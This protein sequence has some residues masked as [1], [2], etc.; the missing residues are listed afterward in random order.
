MPD[1]RSRTSDASDRLALRVDALEERIAN[2]DETVEALNETIT[3]Q[4]AAI[5]ALKRKLAEMME[6]LEDAAAGVLPI[7]RPP[8]HY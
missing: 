2:Q 3:A 1:E 6:R 7:D 5:D 4:W 8:P